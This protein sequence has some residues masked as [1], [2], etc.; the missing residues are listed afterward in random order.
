MVGI[1]TLFYFE[2]IYWVL[3]S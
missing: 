3:W 1:V 2:K